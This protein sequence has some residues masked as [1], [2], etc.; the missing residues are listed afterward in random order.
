MIVDTNL[1]LAI[2][3]IATLMVVSNAL[4]EAS[5]GHARTVLGVVWYLTTVTGVALIVAALLVLSGNAPQ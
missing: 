1:L 2:G 4:Y 5:S 3:I